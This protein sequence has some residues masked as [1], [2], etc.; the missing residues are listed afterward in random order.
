METLN[1][2]PCIVPSDIVEWV[3]ANKEKLIKILW[4]NSN[5]ANEIT[6]TR[7]EKSALKTHDEYNDARKSLNK[8]ID[9]N[10]TNN[11]HKKTQI[12]INRIL[13]INPQ[14]T[15]IDLIK[16]LFYDQEWDFR[17]DKILRA[18]N[19]NQYANALDWEYINKNCKKVYSNT[20]KYGFNGVDIYQD[21]NT[22]YLF[23]KTWL[24]IQIYDKWE[25]EINENTEIIPVHATYNQIYSP[26]LFISDQSWNN[27]LVWE[28]I[29]YQVK[30]DIELHKINSIDYTNSDKS[31]LSIRYKWEWSDRLYDI[32]IDNKI[33]IIK[34]KI[35]S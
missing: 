1:S 4:D 33:C 35:S 32:L 13:A 5:Q 30:W 31:E 8:V 12:L 11:L 19:N 7:Y 17:N 18:I 15:N 20:K 29:K 24:H 10:S 27:W 22:K 9:Y 3:F 23:R 26:E 21:N 2:R 25:D 6:N 14:E 28:E 34:E 16:D